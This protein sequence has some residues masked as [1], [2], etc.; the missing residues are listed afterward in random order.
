M[1]ATPSPLPLDE[2]HAEW[3]GTGLVTADK[4]VLQT[5]P[6]MDPVRKR[7]FLVAFDAVAL[8]ER[9]KGWVRVVFLDSDGK[10]ASGWVPDDTLVTLPESR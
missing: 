3:I 7:L 1:V 5:N 8:L 6:A 4:A 10:P 2:L 9:R